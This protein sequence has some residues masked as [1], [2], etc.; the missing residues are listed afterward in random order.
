MWCMYHF[1]VY[2]Q[3]QFRSSAKCN[4]D[5]PGYT[6]LSIEPLDIWFKR[7]ISYREISCRVTLKAV[8]DVIGQLTTL[9]I[10]SP[11][12]TFCPQ[13][14]A[15]N[16]VSKKKLEKSCINVF[17]NKFILFIKSAQSFLSVQSMTVPF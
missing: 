3:V 15:A 9:R 4:S 13:S 16:A 10:I 17:S 12:L 5:L 8:Q 6:L 2:F 14:V 1:D 7:T 11:C